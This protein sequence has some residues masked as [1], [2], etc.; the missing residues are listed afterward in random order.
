MCTLPLCPHSSVHSLLFGVSVHGFA[1]GP[2][3]IQRVRYHIHP[4]YAVPTCAHVCARETWWQEDKSK[5]EPKH[6]SK[7]MQRKEVRVR[8][9]FY[10]PPFTYESRVLKHAQALL[11]FT[12]SSSTNRTWPLRAANTCKARMCTCSEPQGRIMKTDEEKLKQSDGLPIE[13]ECS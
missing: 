8:P 10:L 2:Q 12:G 1:I 13:N 11:G 4:L 6:L 5:Q 7:R 9:P 3:V